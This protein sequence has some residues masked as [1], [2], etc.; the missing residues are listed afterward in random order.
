ME[1]ITENLTRN[2]ELIWNGLVPM[3]LSDKMLSLGR[4]A[5]LNEE[6]IRRFQRDYDNYHSTYDIEKD[7][8]TGTSKKEAMPKKALVAETRQA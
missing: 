7:E 3:G 1:E 5:L 8:T 6:V 2:H 4:N